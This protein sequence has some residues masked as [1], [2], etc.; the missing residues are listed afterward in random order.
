MLR[1]FQGSFI[2]GEAS[3]HF[4]RVTTSTQRL[5]FRSS[6][7]F[8][9]AGFFKELHFQNSHLFA[10]VI[11]PEQLFFQSKPSTEQQPREN[12]KFFRAVI[13]RNSYLFDGGVV[14]NK[15][16]YRTATFSKQVLLHS[17]NILG[18]AAFWKKLI[19]QKSNIPYYPIFMESYIFRAATFQKSYF[20][21]T[22]LFRTVT[23]SQLRFL[24]TATFSIYRLVNK[25]AQ[26]QL[27][28][29]KVW[30]F[31]LV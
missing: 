12:R 3:L 1:L 15:E 14:Q 13:F 24:P 23:N 18:K 30:E 22:Y 29:V 7:S 16:I 8:R 5:L 31:S 19:F 26:Y 6:Y 10:A 9:A 17:M 20:F 28:T 2:F 21:T 27:D 11:F 4:I 25:W